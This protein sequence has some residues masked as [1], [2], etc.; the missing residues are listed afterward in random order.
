MPVLAAAKR[1]DLVERAGAGLPWV[2]PESRS[3]GQR[4]IG[5]RLVEDRQTHA[6]LRHPCGKPSLF[7][8]SPEWQA[9]IRDDPLSLIGHG[10]AHGLERL[11]DVRVR[12][13]RKQIHQP[14]LLML[15]GRDRIVDNEQTL[16]FINT[17]PSEDKTVFEYPEAH[18]TLEFE[19]DPSVYARDLAAWLSSK[20]SRS[21]AN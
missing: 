20:P 16:A 2:A 11:I 5:D 17:F 6:T 21:G 4:K 19:S 14:L 18:H 13:A 10:F 3:E 1:P 15:A 12:R 7:T 8:D 9:F